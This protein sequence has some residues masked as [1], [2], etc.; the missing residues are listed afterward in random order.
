MLG[1]TRELNEL[2]RYSKRVEH[3]FDKT[4]H[5][6]IVKFYENPTFRQYIQLYSSKNGRYKIIVRKEEYV[7]KQ[8]IGVRLS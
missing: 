5:I 3:D 2:Y 8:K 4:L 7:Y 6:L 1:I